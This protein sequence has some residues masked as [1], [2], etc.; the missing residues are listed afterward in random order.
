L[1]RRF[2]ELII[3]SFLPMAHYNGGGRIPVGFFF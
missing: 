2:C 1:R 3:M